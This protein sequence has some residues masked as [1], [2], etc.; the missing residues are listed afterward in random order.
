MNVQGTWVLI[1]TNNSTTGGT[2][3]FTGWSLTFQKPLPT[4]GL[5]EPG[6]DDVTASF[7]IFTLSQADALSSQEWTAVGPG[8]DRR[9]VQH[10]RRATRRA[11]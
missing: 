1:I 5:G 6:S 11:G 4:T 8:V 2:G 7:R 10:S 9:G 3:T